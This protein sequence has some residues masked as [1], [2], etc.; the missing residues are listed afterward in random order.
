MSQQANS[1]CF[2]GE[3]CA[4]SDQRE[5][6]VKEYVQTAR[7]LRTRLA[8]DAKDA[9]KIE[10]FAFRQEK[11]GS[12]KASRP[13]RCRRQFTLFPL[14]T[15]RLERPTEASGSNCPKYDTREMGGNGLN[16]TYRV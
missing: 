11:R 15:L 14:R 10:F 2:L 4:L 5:W 9:R 12:Q 7:S 1:P 8:Q 16:F 3:L 6:A 13:L